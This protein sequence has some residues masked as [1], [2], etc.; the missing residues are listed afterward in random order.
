MPYDGLFGDI[1]AE[2]VAEEFEPDEAAD[3]EEPETLADDDEAPPAD[4]GEANYVDVIDQ[5]Q[6]AG[7]DE[8]GYER[9]D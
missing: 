2:D 8:D 4:P 3:P 6:P 5:I 7:V 9:E 1:A